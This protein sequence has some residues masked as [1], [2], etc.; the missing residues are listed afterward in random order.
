MLN[1]D[2]MCEWWSELTWVDRVDSV[3]HLN[4]Y[5]DGLDVVFPFQSKLSEWSDFTRPSII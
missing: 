2:E 1:I 3:D 4:F 5:R